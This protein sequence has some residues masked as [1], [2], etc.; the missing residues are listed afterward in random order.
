MPTNQPAANE[1]TAIATNPSTSIT[2]AG[3][4]CGGSDSAIPALYS[5]RRG[6]RCKHPRTVGHSQPARLPPT[7]RSELTDRRL[8]RRLSESARRPSVAEPAS[9]GGHEWER[10]RGAS[11]F[12]LTEPVT[13]RDWTI[14]R[15]RAASPKTLRS[16]GRERRHHRIGFAYRNRSW[17]ASGNVSRCQAAHCRN[18]QG[19][20]HRGAA[21]AARHRRRGDRTRCCFRA[22]SRRPVPLSMPESSS[23][24]PLLTLM[25]LAVAPRA[26]KWRRWFGVDIKRK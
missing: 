12:W 11:H 10:G 14:S 15:P 2:R 7:V 19:A 16:N 1:T 26:P 5:T 21:Y 22:G 20:R 25:P 13:L 3:Q 24:P 18:G 9:A 8:K 23:R 4:C 17:P 6:A